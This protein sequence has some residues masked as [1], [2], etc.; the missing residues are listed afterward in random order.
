MRDP[1]FYMIDIALYFN[2]LLRDIRW[3]PWSFLVHINQMSNDISFAILT[4]LSQ[5]QF[6]KLS[7]IMLS[8]D[9]KKSSIKSMLSSSLLLSSCLYAS[10]YL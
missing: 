7:S 8:F 3:L 9:Y 10:E 1:Y 4:V 5:Y 2:E 6:Q